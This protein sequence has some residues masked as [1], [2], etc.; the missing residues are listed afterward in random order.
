LANFFWFEIPILKPTLWNQKNPKVYLVRNSGLY[1]AIGL[2]LV[3]FLSWKLV[4]YKSYDKSSVD[5][6]MLN[7][8]HDEIGDIPLTEQFKDN[9]ITTATS[10][11]DTSLRSCKRRGILIRNGY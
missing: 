11:S 5:I 2:C 1:S 6:G 9:S 4:E 8:A 3:L 10:C 7:I